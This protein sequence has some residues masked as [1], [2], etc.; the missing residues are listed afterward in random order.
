MGNQKHGLFMLLPPQK[1]LR[2]GVGNGSFVK[3]LISAKVHNPVTL[4]VTEIHSIK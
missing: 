2:G 4:I 1:S 3:T